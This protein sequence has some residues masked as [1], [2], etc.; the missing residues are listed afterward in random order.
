MENTLKYIISFLLDIPLVDPFWITYSDNEKDWKNYKIVIKPSKFFSKEVFLQD[1]SLPKLPLQKLE[2]VPFLYGEALVERREAYFIIHADLI[3]SSFFLLSRYEE[4]VQSK[5]DIHGR[6]PGASS[7]PH[8]AGFIE[9]SPVDEYGRILRK[10]LQLAGVQ[11]PPPASSYSLHLS[12]DV[13]CPYM[14]HN[15]R[16]RLGGIKR[17]DLKSVHASLFRKLEDDPVYSFPFLFQENQKIQNK[18]TTLFFRALKTTNKYDKPYYSY[19]SSQMKALLSLCDKYEVDI[20]LHPSYAAGL[21]P[22]LISSEKDYLQQAVKREVSLSRH[23]FLSLREPKDYHA[24]IDAGIMHDYTMG[25]ADLAG[26]RLGTSRPVRWIDPQTKLLTPLV[27]HPLV[28]MDRTLDAYM[29]L[30]EEEAFNC[31]KRLYTSAKKTNG[32]MNL[33]FHNTSVSTNSTTYHRSLY[34]RIITQIR[35]DEDRTISTI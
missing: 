26:F 16:S 12:H 28:Y 27:L 18:R 17:M 24:L 22:S 10:Y 2:G 11:V 15:L 5:R 14:Y 4:L 31:F 6:F 34:Q 7:L 3:A 30:D 21:D 35:E 33:L 25:Y 13:D 20:G 19:S 32:E 23:H 29:S 9:T 8:R 1:S